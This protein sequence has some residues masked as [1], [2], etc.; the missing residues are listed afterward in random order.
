MFTRSFLHVCGG[1]PR[2]RS[3]R[4]SQVWFSPRMWRWSY[5]Y[6]H[7][8]QYNAVFSTYVEVILLLFRLVSYQYSFLH[9][10]GGDP[11]FETYIAFALWFSPRMWRWSWNIGDVIVSEKVFSTYVEV[12]LFGYRTPVD[13]VCF[14]HV[15][16]GDPA[17]AETLL[18]STIV[19][20]TYVEVILSYGNLGLW[21]WC[22]LHVCGGDPYI[23]FAVWSKNRFSPRMWRWS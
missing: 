3:S 2:I 22:F 13:A 8:I 9:V 18:E 5:Q 7:D 16:G 15:C 19:F 11:I 12:I 20:S 1:D 23:A 21:L 4:I 10:C 6:I 14:L 17:F